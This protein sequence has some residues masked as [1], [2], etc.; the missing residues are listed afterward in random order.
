MAEKTI[1]SFPGYEF[2]DGK[3]LYRGDDLGFGGWVYSQEGMYRN[4]ALLDVAS[5]HPHSIVAMNC[6][7]EYTKNFQE[8]MDFRIAIKHKDYDTAR[9]M[10][11]GKLAKYLENEDESVAKDLSQAAKIAINSCYG[12]TSAN[13]DNPFRDIRNKNNI[14]AL[15][16]AL[17]MRTLQD[18]VHER[19]YTVASIRTDSI[20]IPDATPEIIEFC[21]EFAKQYGYTFEHEA[22]YDRMCLVNKSAYIAKYSNDTVINGKHAGQWTATATQFQVPYVFKT[23]FS[24]EPITFDDLCETKEVKKGALY[25]DM[26]ESLPE[27]EHDYR[28]VGRIGQFCPVKPGKGGGLLVVKRDD[29]YS[30]AAGSK[31]YRW[32]DAE[33]IRASD[34]QDAIDRSYYNALVDDAV[35]TI[36]Q[37]VDFYQF[38]SEDNGIPPWESAD[39]P[40]GEPAT[41][42]FD[43]R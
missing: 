13:F 18:E 39:E 28:F 36:S 4:V 32:I 16:G 10:F 1:N 35:E 29:K 31:G 19:G 25:L 12:L 14:V 6:F 15:R 27:G 21:M 9:K 17:F 37:Y 26:N 42:P 38:V 7:G 33:L 43:V 22:T 2:K 24:K 3:N 23:L 40:Y 30:A 34:S 11:G 20:K 5:L 41:T 8:L